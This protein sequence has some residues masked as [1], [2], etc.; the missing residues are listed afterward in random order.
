MRD[1]ADVLK[2]MCK[3]K[4]KIGAQSSPDLIAIKYPGAST[5]TLKTG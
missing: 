5:H 4:A 3:I 2:S 1:S